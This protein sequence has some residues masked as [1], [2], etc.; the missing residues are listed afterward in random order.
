MMNESVSEQKKAVRAMLKSRIE[1][2]SAKKK[3]EKSGLACNG[4]LESEEFR[5]AKVVMAYLSTPDEVD[6]TMIIEAAWELGKVVL[7]PKILWKTREMIP[8]MIRSLE[9]DLVEAKLGIREPKS[10]SPYLEN[11]IDLILVPAMGFCEDGDRIGHGMG[12]YDRFLAMISGHA[13]SC[14]VGFEEQVLEKLP[15]EEWD[16]RLDMIVTDEKVRRFGR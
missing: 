3:R 14:G 9:K 7:A 5:K 8:V 11:R 16:M 13:V 12:F 4:V 6:T 10:Q 15:R 2:I 1:G